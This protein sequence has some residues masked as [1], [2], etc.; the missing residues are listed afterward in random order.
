MPGLQF[1]TDENGMLVANRI[2]ESYTTSQFNVPGSFRGLDPNRVTG[3]LQQMGL[4]PAQS[5]QLGQA[6][7]KK[8]NGGGYP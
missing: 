4:S 1:G 3:V 5:K 8:A 6:T 2:L 7:A